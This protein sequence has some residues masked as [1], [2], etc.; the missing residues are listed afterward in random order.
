MAASSELFKGYRWKNNKLEEYFAQNF[1][2]TAHYYHEFHF[3]FIEFQVKWF[4]NDKEVTE[5]YYG[6]DLTVI[7]VKDLFLEEEKGKNI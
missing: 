2:V 4:K 6:I 5:S 1:V 3:H 7:S